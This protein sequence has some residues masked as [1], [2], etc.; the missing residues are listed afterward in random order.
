MMAI[1]AWFQIPTSLHYRVLRKGV[2][3]TAL[4][5]MIFVFTGAIFFKDGHGGRNFVHVG[6]CGIWLL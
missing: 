2:V 6:D 4:F 1:F 5:Q 3:A